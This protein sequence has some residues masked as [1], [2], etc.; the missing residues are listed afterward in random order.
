MQIFKKIF[1]LILAALSLPF[2]LLIR[3]LS[4]LVTVRIFV[5][6]LSRIGHVLPQIDLYFSKSKAGLHGSNF[7]MF[8]FSRGKIANYQIKK[9]V[10]RVVPI[11]PFVFWVHK[12]NKRIPGWEKHTVASGLS[13]D[14]SGTSPNLNFTEKELLDG[15]EFLKR[16]GIPHNSSFICF[17]AR[18]ASYLETYEPGMNWD[19]H[20]YRNADI[21]SYLLAV[22]HLV[23]KGYFAVRM[24]RFVSQKL[25]TANPKIIDYAENS[26]TDFFDVYL[27]AHC[28]FFIAGSDGLVY[29]PRIFRRPVTWINYTPLN[30]IRIHTPIKGQLFIPKKLWSLREKC[31]LTFNEMLSAP[32]SEFYRTED[33]QKAGIEVVDNSPE[34]IM[35]VVMEMEERLNGTWN[36]TEEDEELQQIFWRI[37]GGNNEH[38]FFGR[39]GARFLRQHRELLDKSSK[40]HYLSGNSS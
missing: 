15:Q 28:R 32:V 27:S 7:D 19:Y 20:S 13:Y 8:C 26:A 24:G 35:D 2:V 17:N 30:A 16:L 38:K 25:K 36:E 11:V 4:P 14:L 23:S 10:E 33:Y 9:M 37:V 5:L 3:I 18:E 31:F 6:D 29:M 21:N 39:I 40:E 34:E 22:E 12:V 1:N